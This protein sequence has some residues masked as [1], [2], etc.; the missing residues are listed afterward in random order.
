VVIPAARNKDV[1]GLV[2]RS[3]VRAVSPTSCCEGGP[4]QLQL[5]GKTP[6]MLAGVGSNGYTTARVQRLTSPRVRVL[7]I[8]AHG[9]ATLIVR[10]RIRRQ[11]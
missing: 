1:R 10:Q 5:R 8:M 3:A 2:R 7:S 9:W 6:R 11:Q 4:P